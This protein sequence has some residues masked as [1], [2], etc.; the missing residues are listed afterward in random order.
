MHIYASINIYTFLETLWLWDP[1][2][3][4]DTVMLYTTQYTD[5]IWP[6]VTEDVILWNSEQLLVK[7]QTKQVNHLL[8]YTVAKFLENVMNIKECESELLFIYKT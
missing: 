3:Y 4:T 8:I 6:A 7:V 1:Q 5:I 2:M